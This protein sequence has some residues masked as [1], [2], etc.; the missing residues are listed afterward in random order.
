MNFKKMT[1]LCMQRLT[2]FPYIEADFDALTNYELLCKVVEY[3]NKVIANENAQNDAINELAEA[4]TNLKNYVDNYFD[5]LDVQDEINNKL[6]S[7]VEDGTISEIIN[8]EIFGQINSDIS[9]LYQYNVLSDKPTLFIGDSWTHAEVNYG[10]LYKEYVGLSN[11]N[12]FNYSRGGAGFYA[13]GTAGLTFNDLLNNAINEMTTTQKNSIK[14][15]IVGSLLNDASYNSSS[16]QIKNALI[17]F[18][19][20]VNTNFPNA[21]V[22]IIGCGYR[23]GI[24]AD[25]VNAR[26]NMPNVVIPSITEA[27]LNC[28]QPIY[29]NDSELWLRDSRWYQSDNMHP[30]ATGQQIIAKRLIRAL[31]GQFD[32]NYDEEY[33]SVLIKD[34]ENETFNIVTQF[35]NNTGLFTL[36]DNYRIYGITSL[37]AR[38]FNEIGTMTSNI[39]HPSNNYAMD[40]P[41]VL[42]VY[43]NENNDNYVN[44]YL[45][46]GSDNKVYLY[47]MCKDSFSNIVNLTLYRFHVMKSLYKI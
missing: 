11:S 14:Q 19:T 40:I 24:T 37:T 1:F 6:D 20:S 5:N 28:K 8:Q 16:S 10:D 27:N 47:P 22:Y 12:Y 3:L 35:I 32:I 38:Q 7:L 17:T 31:N 9:N 42:R 41:V 29:I 33:S 30:N 36:S 18:M 44:A 26:K 15:I 45:R 34:T 39:I 2:N 23:V 21:T 13:T 25:D 4:F 46:I 43:L